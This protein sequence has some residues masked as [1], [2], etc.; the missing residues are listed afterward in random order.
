MGNIT[1]LTERRPLSDAGPPEI[2]VRLATARTDLAHADA[3]R[4]H[5]IAAMNEARGE[6]DRWRELAARRWRDW[7]IVGLVLGLLLG[8]ALGVLAGVW[9]ADLTA[10]GAWS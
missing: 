9:L 4:W 3:A 5:A 7:L 1:L 10:A 6:A 2:R 8:L